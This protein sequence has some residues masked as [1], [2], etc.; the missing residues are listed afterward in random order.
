MIKPQ[1]VS[2][3]TDFDLEKIRNFKKG[4]PFLCLTTVPSYGILLK[5]YDRLPDLWKL[6]PFSGNTVTILLLRRFCYD[7]REKT[8]DY[9]G[10]RYP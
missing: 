3:S 7:K 2:N 5:V 1:L 6:Q 9:Y 4:Y 10:L 8:G